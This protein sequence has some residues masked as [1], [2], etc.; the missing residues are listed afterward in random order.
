MKVTFKPTGDEFPITA[1]ED[2]LTAALR[3][4]VNLQY[5]C[6]HG[7]CSSCKHWLLEGDVD[8]SEAS[9]YAIP[10]DEREDGAILLCCSYPRSDIVIEIDQHEGIEELPSLVPPSRRVATV[11]DV[12][13]MTDSL[14]E[15]RVRLDQPL[16]FRAGQYAEFVVP[17][18]GQ[19]RSFSFVNAPDDARDCVF[20]IKHIDGGAFSTVLQTL[21]PGDRLD[22]EAPFGTMFYRETGRPIL[23]AATGSGIAPIVSILTDMARRGLDVPIRLYYGA[24]RSADLIY[25]DRLL[26][27][28]Q[29]FSD[30]Q[31]I[32]CL[33]QDTTSGNAGAR[34]GRVNRVIAE[35]LRDASGHD[36]YLCGS[37]KMCDSVRLLLEAKG[38][39]DNRIHA[40]RFFAATAP[41]H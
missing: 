33:S 36:A 13:A 3:H 11:T 2:I 15:L 39:P 41:T 9:V 10:R 31:F 40:D 25:R 1:G 20:C 27:L 6:R 23:A 30:F 22:T 34:S 18:T 35:D 8:D 14:I 26:A 28:A 19:R 7:N 21:R 17:H 38:M 37:P 32:A 5:G 16:S 12:T 24:R 29:R 4:G